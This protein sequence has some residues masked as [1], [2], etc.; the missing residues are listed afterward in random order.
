MF[1][2]NVLIKIVCA[3]LCGSLLL[4]GCTHDASEPAQTQEESNAP[5]TYT[6]PIS[7]ANNLNWDNVQATLSATDTEQTQTIPLTMSHIGQNSVCIY[8][9]DVDIAQYN[10]ICFSDGGTHQSV[11]APV[12]VANDGYYMFDDYRLGFFNKEQ[13]PTGSLEQF[14][15]PYSSNMEKE[16]SVWLPPN[17]NPENSTP[18]SVIYMTDGQNLFD[19]AATEHG[20]WSVDETITAQVRNGLPGQVIVGIDNADEYRDSQLTPD[21]GETVS[22]YAEFNH[23]TGEE[24]STFVVNTLMPYINS[25]YHV[26]T[27]RN[28]TVIAG[29]SSGGI[30]AFYIGMEHMD[31][32]GGIAALSPAFMLYDDSVWRAY[33]SKFDFADSE[34]L[35]KLYI[36]NGQ[37]DELEQELYGGTI[38]MCDRL[39]SL[40]YPQNKIKFSTL[41]EGMHNEGYWRIYF[42]E[43]ITFLFAL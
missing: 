8:T 30:E 15:L 43:A 28:D 14:T 1:E 22:N 6:I 5:A 10:R 26:S 39:N 38:D 36:Y 42:P 2:K 24:F 20:D 40:G 4:T 3:F 11:T 41:P 33:L 35:P 16:I 23:G 17:Y 19:N 7:F 31:R 21:L 25:H 29:S 34:T 12:T 37:G 13:E 9:L 18:Y 32:F 27:G